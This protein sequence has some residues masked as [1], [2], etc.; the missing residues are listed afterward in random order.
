MEHVIIF[1]Y[2]YINAVA[3]G[4]TCITLYITIGSAPP[5]RVLILP[6]IE[7]VPAASFSGGKA[8]GA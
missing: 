1:L 3:N 8:A 4:E 5:P 7:R 2:M 6:S